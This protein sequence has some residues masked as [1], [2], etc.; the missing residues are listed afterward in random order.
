MKHCAQILVRLYARLL[1][2]YPRQYRADYGEELQTVFSLAVNEAAQRGRFSIIRLGWRELR[3]LP[4]AVIREHGRERRK[5]K[6]ETSTSAQTGAERS[7]WGET[8]AGLWPFLL[9]PVSVIVEYLTM[10]AWFQYSETPK[11]LFVLSLLVGLGV[12]WAKGWPRWSYLYLGFAMVV[13]GLAIGGTVSSMVFT[14]GPEWP[15]LPQVLIAVGAFGLTVGILTLIARAWRPFH[16]LYQD[17]RQDWTR[18]SFGLFTGVLVLFGGGGIDHDE[19]PIFTLNV[20]M[21]SLIVL[22]GALVYLRS[23]TKAQRIL[24]LLVSLTLAVAV[25]VVGGKTFYGTYGA[26]VGVIVSIPALLGLLPRPAKPL[27]AG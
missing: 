20:F 19:D 18:L 1:S 22:A 23:T 2:L 25:R 15:V 6:M 10:P 9:G 8:L 3:D 5:R 17:I 4:G 26:V 7:S 21:P 13:G 24:A 12:G 11:Y 16:S 27:Q 14:V